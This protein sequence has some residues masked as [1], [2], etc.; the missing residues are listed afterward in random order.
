[1]SEIV[2]AT[3]NARYA[4]ASLGLRSLLANLGPDVRARACL[5][6][7]TIKEDPRHIC[8]TLLA[9]DAAPRVIGLGVY[10]WNV[11]QTFEVVRL[12][13]AERPDVCIVLGGPE[14]SHETNAQE[15]VAAADYVIC[16]EGEVS[17]DVL[18]R[19]LLAGDRPRL[20]VI[21]GVLPDME[22]LALPYSLYSDEDVRQRII[23]V[24]ASRGCPFKCE[25]CLSSL[26]KQVRDVPID[27]FLGE[28]ELLLARGVRQF[29]FIDRTFNLKVQ[30]SRAILQFFLDRSVPGLFLH[31]EL[32]PDRLPENV[33]ELAARFPPGAL[34]FEV[35]IQ[36]FNDDVSR[37]ISRKQDNARVEENFRFLRGHTG[38]HLHADL[39]V[40]L[41][42]E[43]LES[44]ARGFDR[45][46]ALG[47]QEIQVGMLKRLRG[48]P[49]IRHDAEWEMVYGVQ[50]PYEVVRTRDLDAPTVARLRRFAKYWDLIHNSG[51]FKET[52]R[53]VLDAGPSAFAEFLALSDW[54]FAELQRTHAISLDALVACLFRFHRER[55]HAEE[56][57]GTMLLRDYV[58]PA[59][60]RVP[61]LLKPY[62]VPL[63]RT[64]ARRDLPRRQ[65]RHLS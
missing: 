40:G 18:C 10:I 41:P 34:Q 9:G 63:Q 59:P 57:V 47:P 31:F 17:F 13:K 55:G 27:A 35:G 61:V 12:L 39:I 26:D 52:V 38:V 53:L 44:F 6:E 36:T 46:V 11:A 21:P 32:I 49:I 33:R 45:L 43:T 28:M 23:Y 3:L 4:H 37:R 58:R 30:T 15:I 2:L 42:G 5:R 20:K 50:P 19:Q 62:A 25:F 7:F 1:M 60:R 16:G 65:A 8:A 51:N 14:V 56:H 29:K 22:T 54:L 64:A 48:T 24:E